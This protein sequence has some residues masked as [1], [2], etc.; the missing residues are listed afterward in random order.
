MRLAA[1]ILAAMALGGAAEPQQQPAVPFELYKGH[2]FVSV[3]VNGQGPYLFGFDTGASGMGRVDSTLTSQLALPKVGEEANSDGIRTVTTDVVQVDRVTL[4]DVEKHG[5]RLLARDYNHG[6]KDH[7]IAGIIGR[8]FFADRLVT[9]DYPHK[10]ISFAKGSLNAGDP[11]VVA[12]GGS[13]VI[14]VCFASGCYPA[15]VD[16]GSSRSIVIPKNLVAKISASPPRPIGQAARTN[17]MA[18]LYEMTLEEPVRVGGITAA[19]QTVLYAEPS[20]AMINVGSDFLKDYVL[21]IDQQHKLLKIDRP[22]S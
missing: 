21:T 20:D 16:T 11:R 8:D 2:I 7:A 18:T 17:S 10:R 22:K 9:I 5:L 4:G 12:Y 19:G 15:K 14:A 13:F 6:R 1:T 3:F